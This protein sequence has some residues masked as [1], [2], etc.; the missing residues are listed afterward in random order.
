[1]RLTAF[2]L[3]MCAF[4][5]AVA[6]SSFAEKFRP[7]LREEKTVL[8]DGV[9]EDWRLEWVSPTKP[10]CSP[11]EPDAWPT[12]PCEGFAFGESGKLELVR[13]RPGQEE[14]RLPISTLFAEC[15]Y[16]EHPGDPGDTALRKWDVRDRDRDEADAPDFAAR[17]KA[18]PL[19]K[20][21]HFADYDHNGR[22]TEF[23]F[24]V[25]ELPCGKRMCVVIGI[26]RNNPRLH[27]F[28]SAKHPGKPLVLQEH[29]WEAL[30]GA[31]GP[32]KVMN[33]KCGDHGYDAEEELELSIDA[34]GIH[35]T[36]YVYECHKDLVRGRLLK[37]S[38]L[39]D[40]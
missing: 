35:A 31:K 30:L 39:E 21:M 7:V 26:S 12:C 28:G 16:C 23:L 27:V 11:E 19:A 17:V 38:G 4:V 6:A 8:V 32:V 36:K 24:Q 3:L 9:K 33:W 15:V 25:G 34:S 22:A 1:M 20:V 5:F 37:K 2:R 29:Q 40:D 10:V 18:R 14:E 13:K